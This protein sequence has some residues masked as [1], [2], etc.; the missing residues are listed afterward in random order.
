MRPA[1]SIGRDVTNSCEWPPRFVVAHMMIL[2]RMARRDG[3]ATGPLNWAQRYHHGASGRA[4]TWRPPCL[5][6]R[7]QIGNAGATS[8]PSRDQCPR[9]FRGQPTQLLVKYRHPSHLRA[10]DEYEGTVVE[11]RGDDL[12]YGGSA[13]NPSQLEGRQ[14][15]RLPPPISMPARSRSQP[16][17]DRRLC[18]PQRQVVSDVRGGPQADRAYSSV[19]AARHEAGLRLG[20]AAERTMIERHA[21]SSHTNAAGEHTNPAASVVLS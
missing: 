8:S 10:S 19:P 3:R 5:T 15:A 20:L 7:S 21:I 14:S 2:C 18:V 6:C 4:S 16:T 17:L 12:L 13:S 11:L 1:P 9:L